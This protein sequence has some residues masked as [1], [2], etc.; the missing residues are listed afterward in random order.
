VT[1]A[2]ETAR[3]SAGRTRPRPEGTARARVL[4]TARLLQRELL[5]VVGGVLLY[6]GGRGLT[7]SERAP[8]LEHARDLVAFE[9]ALGVFW[10]PWL[11]G[12][13]DGSHALVTVANW[14][15][16]WGHWPVIVLTLGWLVARHPATYRRTRNAMA[17][18]G[19]I[20]M[21]VF[22]LY[23]VAPPR[24]ADLGLTDTVLQH[25]E[26]YRVLQ[27]PAFSNLYAAMPSLHVG[28]NLLMGIAIATAA[29][30]WLLRAAGYALPLLMTVSVVM[31][32][33]HYLVDVVA[34]AVVALLGLAVAQRVERRSGVRSATGP[35]G[36]TDGPQ[37]STS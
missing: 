11:Q 14:I 17:A 26:A 28:W 20:G 18:S 27:P 13:V 32:A 35:A 23:P 2:P 16:I 33:N 34:G 21:V 19:A 30:H 10:E 24:L 4:G 8:A 37:Y 7:E 25:S 31:T 9:R 12:L 22:V 29:R 36:S 1:A 3:L 15:Y 5:L 6:F